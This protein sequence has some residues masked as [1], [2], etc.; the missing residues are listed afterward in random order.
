MR[1]MKEIRL[2][3]GEYWWGGAV[4]DGIHMPFGIEA[5]SRGLD[6]NRTANQATPLLLSSKGRY[7]WSDEPFD[8]AFREELLTV[9]SSKGVIELGEGFGSLR[10]AYRAIQ[11]KKFPP[12]GRYPHEIMFSRPQYNT[13]IELMYD[14][15]QDKILKYAEDILAAGMPAGMLIIDCNWH[16]YYGAWDFHPGR[17]PEPRK[18]IER[19]HEMGFHVMLWVCPFV[20]AD[21]RIYRELLEKGFLLR[22][23]DGTP[24]IREWWDGYSAVLD[25]MH[26]G[27][28]SWFQQQLMYL[29]EKYGVDGFKFD[30]GDAMYYED[31]DLSAVPTSANGHSEAYAK[32]GLDYPANEYR[33]CWKMAGRAIA[34]RL[35]DKQHDWGVNGLASLI[36]NGLAQGIIGYSYTCPDMIGGG[37][38]RNFLANSEHLDSELFVRYAQCSALFPMMQ[39]S[40]APWRVLDQEHFEY[41]REA[42]KLHVQF[43]ERIRRLAEQAAVE[44]EP[45]IRMMEYVFPGNSY[46]TIVDQFMLGDRILVAPV[47]QKGATERTVSFP[48]GIWFGDDGSQEEGPCTKVIKAPINRL[49]W[50]TL[51]APFN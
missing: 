29:T 40:A 25:L 26:S 50:Y 30:A 21:S 19:L 33:A 39:F 47:L 4:A 14:Q 41:C 5:F 34:Q 13:W 3:E 51:N 46:E 6:P 23:Q 2:L 44:G 45:I 43:G 11:E 37:E 31:T 27:A 49:P 12:D 36:P 32:L 28:I 9:E 1:R 38:Y 7:I 22:N 17:I 42:A 18:M 48:P 16:D 10:G 35:S 15:E 20:S 24:A 8:F